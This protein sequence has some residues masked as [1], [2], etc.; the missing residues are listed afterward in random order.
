MGNGIIHIRGGNES[1]NHCPF[2]VESVG[3][4]RKAKPQI[5]WLLSNS[6][7]MRVGVRG[8]QC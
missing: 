2:L 8:R 4:E 3:K 5:D 6:V 7:L 1:L